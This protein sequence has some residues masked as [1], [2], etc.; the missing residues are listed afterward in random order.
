MIYA[1]Y[2]FKC[3]KE[4]EIEHSIKLAPLRTHP[5][6]GGILK[7]VFT[8]MRFVLK[9]KGWTRKSTKS[10]RKIDNALKQMG[11]QDESEGWSHRED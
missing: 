8:E 2:C 1:Y 3:Q 4:I 5:N 6:C 9:G 7:R 10:T 11:V